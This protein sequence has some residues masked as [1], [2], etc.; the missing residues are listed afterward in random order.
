LR[1]HNV[2]ARAVPTL[3]ANAAH[4]SSAESGVADREFVNAILDRCGERGAKV[5][6]MRYLDG[7][8]Q[9]EIAEVLGITRRTVFN[10]LRKLSQIAGEL[11]HAVPRPVATKDE[12]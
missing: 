4:V 8:S 2:H 11:L 3:A 10:R 7:M 9:V 6:I 12:E 5:A 1:E